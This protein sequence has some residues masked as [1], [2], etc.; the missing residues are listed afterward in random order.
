MHVVA[1]AAPTGSLEPAP[2]TSL[3]LRTTL[4]NAQIS[5]FWSDDDRYYVLAETAATESADAV[6]DAELHQQWFCFEAVMPT[7]EPDTAELEALG[8]LMADITPIGGGRVAFP[9]GS[10]GR[11]VY[12]VWRTGAMAQGGKTKIQEVRAARSRRRPA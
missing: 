11:R 5:A 12:R 6:G 7:I 8:K 9:I 3:P 1:C 4:G 2:I 10:S